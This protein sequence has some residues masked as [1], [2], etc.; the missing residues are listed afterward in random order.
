MSYPLD[1]FTA[2]AK[3]N[4]DLVLRFAD[5]ARASGEECAQIGRKAATLFVDQLKELKPGKVPSVT[6]DAVTSL[7]SEAEKSREAAASKVKAAIDEWQGSWKDLLSQ[8]TS[9]QQLT[10]TMQVWFR[11]LAGTWAPGA[12]KPGEASPAPAKVPQAA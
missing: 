12:A 10:D 4:G 6:S 7:F 5:I 1:Q 3:A 8:S 9:Q 2:L 11:P